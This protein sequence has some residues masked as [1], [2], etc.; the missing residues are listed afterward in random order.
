MDDHKTPNTIILDL[1][2]AFDT[3]YYDILLYKL[4]FYGVYGLDHKVISSYLSDKKQY[5]M[6]NNKKLRIT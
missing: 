4:I 3:L 5:V 6:F 1:S 2:K